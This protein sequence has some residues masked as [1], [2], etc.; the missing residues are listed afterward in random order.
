M[1]PTPNDDPAEC[2]FTSTVTPEYLAQP[3][4][5][6]PN[7]EELLRQYSPELKFRANSLAKGDA[8]LRDDLYQEGAIGLVSAARRFDRSRG[9]KFATFARLYMKGRMLN[10]LRKENNHWRSASLQDTCYLAEDHDEQNLPQEDCRPI[11]TADAIA[12]TAQSLFYVDL[13]LLQRQLNATAEELTARQRQ[14]FAMRYSQGL[15]P[16][17]IAKWL[18][19]SPARVTQALQETVAKLQRVFARA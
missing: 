17:E 15:L 18:H 12:Q 3:S 11:T 4:A 6:R 8:H 7:E 10:Y 16:S 13:L 19:I 5:S 1:K 14:I 9:I 2:N